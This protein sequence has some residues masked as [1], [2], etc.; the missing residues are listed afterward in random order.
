M[1]DE[2][3]QETQP[4]SPAPPAFQPVEAEPSTDRYAPPQPDPLTMTPPSS[5]A[6]ETPQPQPFSST[7]AS[8]PKGKKKRLVLAGIVAAVLVVLIG[9]AVLA[10]N[11]WYQNPDK[12]VG[13]ALVHALDAKTMSF[14]SVSSVKGDTP[15]TIILNGKVKGGSGSVDLT[16]KVKAGGTDYSLKGSATLDTKGDLYVKATDVDKLVAPLEDQGAALLTDDMKQMINDFVAKVNN[17]WIKISTDDVK[18]FS[19]SLAKGEKCMHDTVA[20]LQGDK[21]MSSEL[22]DL[23]KKHKFID[24]S[25]K[26]GSKDGSLGYELKS[27]DNEAKLF[28][29][30]LKNTRFY[31]SLHN[32]DSEITIDEGDVTSGSDDSHSKIEVWI[33][34]WT[35]E[36]TKV[37]MS[38]DGSEASTTTFEP[39]FNKSMT[40]TTP[41]PSKSVKELEKDIQDFSTKFSQ[42]FGPTATDD[43]NVTFGKGLPD[44]ESSDAEVNL[45]S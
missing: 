44:S 14:T 1:D 5:T 16:A 43:A 25:K 30:G 45:F 21:A 24:V 40:I 2:Q 20:K 39:T 29:A 15:A 22:S 4:V 3:K 42:Q 32:C 10:Y 28:M 8:S 33:S 27:N 35:H 34:R 17:H 36:A 23:Y 6:F 31:K 12:V 18:T 7:P 41:S 9:G 38:T 26:L 37:V 13:D 19:D 11:F